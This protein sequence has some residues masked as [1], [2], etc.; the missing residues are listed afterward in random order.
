M[1]AAGE[2]QRLDG[3]VEALGEAAH[4]GGDV[5]RGEVDLAVGVQHDLVDAGHHRA[6]VDA[7]G[8]LRELGQGQSVGV[9]AVAVAPRA[10]ADRQ[11]VE[12][13]GAGLGRGGQRGGRG[14]RR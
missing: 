7:V 12:P 2:H 8:L 5:G 9:L 11:V 1:A 13:L 3:P 4:V 10:G 6:E 14:R